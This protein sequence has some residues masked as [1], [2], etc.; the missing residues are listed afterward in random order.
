MK[1]PV[2]DVII[3]ALLRHDNI[4]LEALKYLPR[5]HQK[6]HRRK[7]AATKHQLW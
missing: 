2:T 4:H 5:G 7:G 3:F 6:Y 1:R